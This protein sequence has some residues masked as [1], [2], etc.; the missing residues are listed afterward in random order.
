MNTLRG[1]ILCNSFDN[2]AN[3]LIE[4]FRNVS[5]ARLLENSSNNLS[6]QC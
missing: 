1:T 6:S 5:T 2:V 3:E 4:L